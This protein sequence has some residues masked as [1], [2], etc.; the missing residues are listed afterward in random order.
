MIKETP[1]LI[2]ASEL[3]ILLAVFGLMF[4]LYIFSSRPATTPLPPGPRGFPLFGNFFDLP[5]SKTKRWEAYARLSKRWGTFR[6][7]RFNRSTLIE[8]IVDINDRSYNVSESVRTRHCHRQFTRD[9]SRDAGK[10]KLD[11]FG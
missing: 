7:P 11:I 3:D 6:S 9:H 2:S 8:D 5:D 1:P 4:A 10:Q